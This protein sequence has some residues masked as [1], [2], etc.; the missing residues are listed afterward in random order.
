MRVLLAIVC[1]LLATACGSSPA[2]PAPVSATPS[3]MPV[4]RGPELTTRIETDESHPPHYT[5]VVEVNC[6]SGGF[7]M[8][9]AGYD[10]KATPREVRYILTSPASD[11]LVFQAFQVHTERV[12]LGSDRTPVRV[13]VSQ[14]QRRHPDARQQPFALAATVTPK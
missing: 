5:L 11:E 10:D 7:A 4:Y 3:D 1:G 12:D 13:L 14:R 6:P 8:T 2:E 9:L